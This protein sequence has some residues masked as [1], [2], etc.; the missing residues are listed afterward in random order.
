MSSFS[1]WH[2][3]LPCQQKKKTKHLDLEFHIWIFEWRNQ[4]YI[5]NTVWKKTKCGIE[6]SCTFCPVGIYI[7]C[8]VYSWKSSLCRCHSPDTLPGIW[9]LSRVIS[10]LHI[11]ITRFCWEFHLKFCWRASHNNR[12]HLVNFIDSVGLTLVILK[13]AVLVQ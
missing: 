13:Q 7:I 8:F 6:E 2:Q 9:T 4:S 1:T 11:I 3:V 12:T 10:V 5:K